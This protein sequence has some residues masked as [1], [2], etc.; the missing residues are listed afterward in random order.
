MTS[1]GFPNQARFASFRDPAGRLVTYK[2]QIFRTLDGSA[3]AD[4]KS[5][6]ASSTAKKFLDGGQLVSTRFLSDPEPEDLFG[7][8]WQQSL[9]SENPNISNINVVEHERIPF[10]SFPYEWPPEMLYRAGVLTIELAESLLSEGFGLKDGTPYNV[11]FK[12]SSPVFIDLLSFERRDAGDPTWLPLAQFERTF[13]LPLLVNKYFGLSLDSIFISNRDGLEP[14]AVYRLCGP[15][16]RLRSPFLSL[17]SIPKWLSPK[18][19]AGKQNDDGQ[20][21]KKK[22]MSNR[23]QAQFIL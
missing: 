2:N 5:F 22:L 8:D 9:S 20:I 3:I 23:D 4:L 13:V 15:L 18:A 19:N 21:Y 6:L 1:S 11:L 16:R 17:V 12:G 7:S 10:Q 14:E